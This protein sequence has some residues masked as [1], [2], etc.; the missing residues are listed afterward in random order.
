MLFRSWDGF[1][2]TV[3]AIAQVGASALTPGSKD[4]A[5]LLRLAPG[6]YV[7]SV[8]A[9]VGATAGQ[10]RTEVFLLAGGTVDSLVHTADLDRNGRISLIELTRVIELYN[11]RNGTNRTGY[12][13]VATGA[14][15]DGF[16]TGTGL[17]A[18]TAP[19]RRHSA[20]S[21]GDGEISLVELT[22]VIE[23]FNY[24]SGTVRT[25]Q[26]KSRSGSEDGFEPG[27]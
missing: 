2:A 9:P 20:D 12:Y 5:S 14:S 15:E 11:T 27:S 3:S 26:Y 10:V 4:S 8:S 19:A 22:R 23:L 6:G 13:T 17:S 1:P 25:G 24:R 21:N 18:K 16:A 7:A